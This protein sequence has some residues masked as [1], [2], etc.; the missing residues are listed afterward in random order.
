VAEQLTFGER[1]GERS[2]IHGDKRFVPARTQAVQ[3]TSPE[4]LTS[5]G[6][7]AHQYGALDIRRP[8]HMARNAIHFG[9]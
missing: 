8:F 5:A 2:A 4:L 1:C 6:L 9:I 3:Q 7:A